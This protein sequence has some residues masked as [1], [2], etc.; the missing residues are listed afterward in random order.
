MRG[1][2]PA[3]GD[4]AAVL[5]IMEEKRE[6]E[7]RRKEE[8][9]VEEERR[10]E[11]ERAE[12]E[13]RK[14]EKRVEEERRKEEK[15]VE[16]ERRKE[17]ERV[18]EER[19]KEERLYEIEMRR[20]EFDQKRDEEMQTLL[21]SISASPQPRTHSPRRRPAVPSPPLPH[22]RENE[23][24]DVFLEHFETM[25]A[26][27]EMDDASKLLYLTG[28]LTETYRRKFRGLR[29]EPTESFQQFGDRLRKVFRYWVNLSE[30]STLEDLVL[31]EQL[32]N[33]VTEG[34]AIYIAE[35]APKTFKEAIERADRYAEARR[36]THIAQG[37]SRIANVDWRRNRREGSKTPG[38]QKPPKTSESG[39]SANAQQPAIS[40]TVT[41]FSCGQKGHY[42]SGCPK[43]AR[44]KGTAGDRKHQLALVSRATSNSE[45][46]DMTS[47]DPESLNY[48]LPFFLCLVED[49]VMDAIRDTGATCLM[50]DETLVPSDAKQVGTT[51][52]KAIQ[53]CFDEIR[54]IVEMH[55][56]TPYF[57]GKVHAVT[58]R[59]PPYSL[60][61]GNTVTY[62]SGKSER[63]SVEIPVCAATGVITRAAAKLQELPR[64]PL[65]D[66]MQGNSG[67]KVD[68]QTIMTLQRKDPSLAALR[69]QAKSEEEPTVD[70]A[71]YVL[72]S[73]VL[74][75]IFRQHGAR[76]K[77]LMVPRELRDTVMKL[78]H[79]TPFSGHLGGKRTRERLWRDFYWPGVVRDVRKYCASCDVCQ[80]TTPKGYNRRVPMGQVPIVEVEFLGHS[81]GCGQMT[82]QEDKER[83]IRDA[84][85]PKT[86]KELR[87]FLGLVGYYRRFVPHFSDIAL[88]LTQK[89]RGKQPQKIVWS[90]ESQEAFDKLKQALV[91]H[92]VL[93][94]PDHGQ[95][96]VLRTDASG[97]GLGAV[98]LQ[99]REGI[100]QPVSYASKKLSD[101]EKRY[102]TIEQECLAVV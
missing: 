54:P 53:T 87:A 58:L 90:D 11:K 12:E 23:D 95:Q 20:L 34:L 56:D 93:I 15:R 100:L 86:K 29:K 65:R 55:V 4:L 35:G 49:R 14:E 88:P 1:S 6:E 82:T 31:L 60:V 5:L 41:C 32:H 44:Q 22:F 96:F 97:Q 2:S 30:A 43:L 89:T 70:G 77:Q 51:Q 80:R 48:G 21:G 52:L 16:E 36:E 40:P 98:L 38:D 76:Y 25:A 102:H 94:L 84:E 42:R 69:R 78:A 13:R 101:A 83:K 79:D 26:R 64:K 3:P 24:I 67:L 17:K 47:G 57:V 91:S 7:E 18:E 19:R 45:G 99:E 71:S 61:I 62:A 66:P 72:K 74:Y 9:R 59:N 28:S 10:K 37:L 39:K 75:R 81:V 92:P 46:S 50:V 27:Y 33:V 68:L 73:G 63:V 8:K 85:P